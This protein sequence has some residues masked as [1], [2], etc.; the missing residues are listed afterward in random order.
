M[1]HKGEMLDLLSGSLN[2]FYKAIYG[3]QCGEFVF[4]CWRLKGTLTVAAF[5]YYNAKR[6][7][8]LPAESNVRIGNQG[9]FFEPPPQSV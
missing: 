2:Y 4:G 5:F 7:I 3:H 6:T 1:M 8:L 9:Q